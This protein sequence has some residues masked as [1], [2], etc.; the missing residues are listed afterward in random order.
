MVTYRVHFYNIDPIPGGKIEPGETAKAALCRELREEIDLAVREE[1]LR[2]YCRAEHN[3]PDFEVTMEFFLC[4][5][6]KEEV[7]LRVHKSAVWVER[8]EL[9]QLDWVEADFPVISQLMDDAFIF[10]SR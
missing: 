7:Q 9:S 1:E 2:F 3:Y 10:Q 8:H 5:I 4:P 6:E